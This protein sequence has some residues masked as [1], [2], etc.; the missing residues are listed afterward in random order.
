M[1]AIGQSALLILFAA[2]L[3]ATESPTVDLF[4]GWSWYPYPYGYPY[5]S[6]D[7][8]WRDTGCACVPY[9]GVSTLWPYAGSP[10]GYRYGYAPYPYWGYDYGVRVTFRPGDLTRLPNPKDALL[11]SLPGSA[12][13]ALKDE[14][15]EKAWDREIETFLSTLPTAADRFAT[16]NA[17]SG[18]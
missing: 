17:T 3:Y 18:R 14:T 7:R 15:R 12:P 13:T 2:A 9:A 4:A 8:W 11:P 1:K 6:Y 16:T 10:W 5:G